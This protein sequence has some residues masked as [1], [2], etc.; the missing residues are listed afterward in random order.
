MLGRA[1]AGLAWLA[2]AANAVA[3]TPGCE[4]VMAKDC[5][6]TVAREPG[7]SG[8]A[9]CL[10]CMQ[11]HESDLAKAGCVFQ[12]PAGFCSPNVPPPPHPSPPA[13]PGAKDVLFFAVDD[14]RPSLGLYGVSEVHSP[15]LDALAERSLVF[16]RMYTAVSVCAPARS[17]ILTGRRPDT[18][19]NWSINN[20]EYWRD[21]LPNASSLPQYFV[22]HGYNVMGGA[23]PPR[24]F[25]C[26]QWL[27]VA[28]ADTARL[29]GSQ[30]GR[31]HVTD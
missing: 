24:A 3:A 25:G 10:A 26:V 1:A 18:T 13:P 14:L 4:T 12:D 21:V 11:A 22:Q 29:A 15:N 30:T 20:A 28:V 7:A 27:R 5:G 17:A 6:G 23:Y 2:A 9:A 19:H 31:Q 16:D 8:L